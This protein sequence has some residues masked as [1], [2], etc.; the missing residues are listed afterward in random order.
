MEG[1]RELLLQFLPSSGAFD[2]AHSLG[3]DDAALLRGWGLNVVRLGVMWPATMP[4][5]G[6]VNETYLG[7]GR[8]MIEMLHEFG[9]ATLVGSER[10][11][12]RGLIVIG[13]ASAE[14]ARSLLAIAHD[15]HLHALVRCDPLHRLFDCGATESGRETCVSVGD[16]SA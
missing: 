7:E 4:A 10:W 15:D 5:R 8:D 16:G 12:R 1:L 2:L 13:R 6:V 3:R 11:R 9:I 14:L